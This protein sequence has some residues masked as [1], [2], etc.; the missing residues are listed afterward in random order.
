MLHGSTFYMVVPWLYMLHRHDNCGFGFLKHY[1]MIL[2]GPQNSEICGKVGDG[3]IE[4]ASLRKAHNVMK[5]H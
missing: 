2:Q 4:S 5:P 1:F 3:F